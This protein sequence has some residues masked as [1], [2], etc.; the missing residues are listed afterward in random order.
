MGERT[1]MSAGIAGPS[2][3]RLRPAKTCYRSRFTVRRCA[4]RQVPTRGRDG[5]ALTRNQGQN[6]QV[7]GKGMLG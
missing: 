6:E 5:S 4:L 7:E 3:H 1:D 2:V